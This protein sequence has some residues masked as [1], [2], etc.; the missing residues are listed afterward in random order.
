M[1]SEY[2]PNLPPIEKLIGA[3]LTGRWGGG[4]AD[5]DA[6]PI[7][8]EHLW[9]RRQSSMRCLEVGTL[10]PDQI[11]WVLWMWFSVISIQSGLQRLLKSRNLPHSVGANLRQSMSALNLYLSLKVQ[12]P[13]GK[14]TILQPFYLTLFCVFSIVVPGVFFTSVFGAVSFYHV[15][16]ISVLCPWVSTVCRRFCGPFW[17]AGAGQL[18]HREPSLC[19]PPGWMLTSTCSSIHETGGRQN[20]GPHPISKWINKN[21]ILT[22]CGS[23]D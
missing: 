4:A 13:N 15:N 21:E 9:H 10:E 19:P 11:E 6:R 18:R 5:T 16:Y 22:S 1:V 12:N 20:Y 3:V 14:R 2:C 23:V 8:P 7:Q 17:G